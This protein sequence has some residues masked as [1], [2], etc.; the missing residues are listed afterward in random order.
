MS[1]A[2]TRI[3]TSLAIGALLTACDKADNEA[4]II[5]DVTKDQLQTLVI[6]EEQVTNEAVFSNTNK[7][8]CESLTSGVRLN[9]QM[10]G[11]TQVVLESVD[12]NPIAGVGNLQT[13]NGNTT[14]V[15]ITDGKTIITLRAPEGNTLQPGKDYIIATFPCDLY[16]GYRLSIYK[17]GLVAHYFGVHQ[18]AEAGQY[19]T[20]PDLEESELEFDDPN[21]PLVEEE[22]PGLNAQTK[23]ALVTY[24]K[25]PTEENKQALL[26]VM[27]IRYDKVVARK[28]AKLRELE[29]EA[30]H[31]SL[32]DEMQAI[33]DEMVENREIRLEQ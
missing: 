29:R 7:A 1:T 27:G 33:V 5:N 22:R 11:V 8:L 15:E 13:E 9:F 31:Q 32:V 3:M 28:K 23:T 14:I 10:E 2:M 12:N 4:T 16:G 18:V 26:E 24:Q 6:L 30:K 25:N 20:P 19:I 17:D 21:A